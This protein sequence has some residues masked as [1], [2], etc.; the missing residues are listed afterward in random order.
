[1][2]RWV[3]IFSLP[4]NL[5]LLSF[6]SV[7]CFLFS[8]LIRALPK[9]RHIGKRGHFKVHRSLLIYC[10]MGL[11]FQFS[12]EPL[13]SACKLTAH[14]ASASLWNSTLVHVSK[15]PAISKSHLASPS[16]LNCHKIPSSLSQMLVKYQG[17]L[18]LSLTQ[19]SSSRFS[20]INSFLIKCSCP[21]YWV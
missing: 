8:A 7:R 14:I 9:W 16:R 13:Q 4:E 10:S 6:F 11:P 19:Q 5:P 3:S 21:S 12:E 2:E 20:R 18:Y 17:D 15:R 1:M